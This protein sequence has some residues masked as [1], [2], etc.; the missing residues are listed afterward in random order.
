MMPM[1]EQDFPFQE[2]LR[3]RMQLAIQAAE[4]RRAVSKSLKSDA[5]GVNR[6]QNVE[7]YIFDDVA[8]QLELIN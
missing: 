4:N 6:V 7:A 5:N 3:Q 2:H 1:E 8:C